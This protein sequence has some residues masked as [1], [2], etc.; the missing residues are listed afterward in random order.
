MRF[1]AGQIRDLKQPGD[2]LFN[3]RC[4]GCDA[5]GTSYAPED[6]GEVPYHY[7]G[8]KDRTP[9]IGFILFCARGSVYASAREHTILSCNP[10]T[11]RASWLCPKGCHSW[12]TDGVW[13]NC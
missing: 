9:R 7:E 8:C 5:H 11:V 3:S 2:Y 12:I 1:V 13:S 10:L 6:G 4:V